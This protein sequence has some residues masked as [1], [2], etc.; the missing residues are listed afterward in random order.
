MDFKKYTDAIDREAEVILGASDKVWD[1]AETAFDEY[2]SM[3][4]LCEALEKEGFTVEKGIGKVPTAFSGR[5]GHGKPVVGLLGEYDGLS[6]LSQVSGCPVNN[7]VV[8]GGVGHGCGHNLLG[9]GALGAAIAVKEYLQDTG[10]E[11]TVVFYGCPGEEGGSGKAFMAREGVFDECDFCITW[12]PGATNSVSTGSSL[13]NYQILYKFDGLAAH[14][15]GAPHLGRGALDAVTLMNVGIQFLREHV[16]PEARM[17][18]AVTDTGGYSPNVVQPH[19]EVLYLLRAPE[20][21]QVQSIFERVNDIA[22]GAALM[23]GTKMSYDFIKACSNI[24]LNDVLGE[25]L[26]KSLEKYEPPKLTPDEEKFLTELDKTIGPEQRTDGLKNSLKF[27][28][29][30]EH[31][32]VEKHVGELYHDFVVPYAYNGQASPGSSDVGDVSWVCPTAQI[33]TA[34]WMASTPGHSW[35]VVAQGKESVAHRATLYAAKVMADT[36][37]EVMNNPEQLQAAKDEYKKRVPNGY[38]CPIP[39]GVKP[40]SLTKL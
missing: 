8:P 25:Q 3:D 32:F 34:T 20:T 1:A 18:Y 9:A 40:R 12:H 24:I 30:E 23:T 38:K 4:A 6:G 14:A 21:P 31:D 33:A 27:L 37:L 16:I 17:H 29:G 28:K 35:Q 15:A 36:C 11:G 39:A 22:Q 5:F 13:A 19:A 2:K 26:Q 10:K 7:P